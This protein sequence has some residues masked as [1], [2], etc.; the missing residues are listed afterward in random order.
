M[1]SSL[2]EQIKEIV[3][4][5]VD[6]Y[7]DKVSQEFQIPKDELFKLWNDD[8][9]AK[10][11]TSCVSSMIAQRQNMSSQLNAQT[12]PELIE[13][14]RSRKLKT[15]GSKAEIIERLLDHDLK[16]ANTQNV[17]KLQQLTLTGKKL[18]S[19][20]HMIT[21]T[22]S[23]PSPNSKMK[24]QEPASTHVVSKLIKPHVPVIEVK[25]NKFNNIEHIETKLVYDP[26]IQ[27]IIGR[28][29]YESGLIKT[30]TPEDIDLCRKFKFS[31]VIPDN[32]D[33]DDDDDGAE[34]VN[35]EDAGQVVQME[36]D[37]VQQEEEEEEEEEDDTACASAEEEEY[38]Y[39]D[40]D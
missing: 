31:Y 24:I 29:D 12:K 33:E 34:V 36:D 9:R 14:C 16:A 3:D 13:L 20:S 18:V 23:F 30:L 21:T 28:Q 1:S 27:K 11:T 10:T 19:D 39:E 38:A 17:D 8:K 5:T 37:D 32:L 26:S 6:T 7:L 4:K 35:D 22:A 40:E 2:S 25:K 15:T